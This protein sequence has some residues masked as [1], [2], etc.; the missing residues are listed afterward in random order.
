MKYPIAI[1]N[2]LIDTYGQELG[3]AYDIMCAFMKTLK[4]SS[5]GEKVKDSGLIGM[6]PAFHGHAHSRSCQVNW[7]P[8]YV[9][10]VGLEDFKTTERTFSLSNELAT[11]T[12]MCSPFHRRQHLDEFFNFLDHDKYAS[13]GK[14]LYS[15]YREALRRI[16]RNSAQLSSLES[17]LHTTSEDY[18]RYL[19][20]ERAYFASLVKEPVEVAQRFEY[21]ETLQKLQ[22]ATEESAS[23]KRD[24]DRM[25]QAYENNEPAQGD[26]GKI[27]SRYTRT[28]NRVVI[29]DEEVSRLE[30]VLGIDVRWTRISP[31]YVKCMKD[32]SERQYRLALDELERLVV[33]RLLEL[34]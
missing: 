32:L 20:E 6:V 33:Q 25:N 10:G 13:S 3:Q 9:P 19:N 34:T 24:Y 18:E 22:K 31:E 17:T 28:A 2:R 11:G 7:H 16:L 1:T 23:A 8:L 27:K 26:V 15:N 29:L 21:F 30:H 4:N 5:I 14:F 12:R